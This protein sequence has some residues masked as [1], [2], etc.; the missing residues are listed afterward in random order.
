MRVTLWVTG[1]AML[2]VLIG[3]IGVIGCFIAGA[4]DVRIYFM[5]V[6]VAALVVSGVALGA[7][8]LVG[9]YHLYLRAFTNKKPTSYFTT[10]DRDAEGSDEA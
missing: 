6:L 5:Y 2:L 7:A 8:L 9:L 1:V 3:G 10:V 4:P